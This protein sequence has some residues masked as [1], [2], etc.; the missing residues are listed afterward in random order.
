MAIAG[1]LQLAARKIES[2]ALLAIMA[3]DAVELGDAAG[4]FSCFHAIAV[5]D[6]GG[7]MRDAGHPRL[8]SA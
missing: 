3:Y 2:S 1:T 5:A 7:G 8:A 6:S 4:V